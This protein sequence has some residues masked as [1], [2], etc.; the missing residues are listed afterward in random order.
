MLYSKFMCEEKASN[1]TAEETAYSQAL[2]FILDQFETKSN[3]A[4]F[5]LS[6]FS[7]WIKFL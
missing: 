2:Q 3:L 5:N 4:L 7:K 1:F 6:A